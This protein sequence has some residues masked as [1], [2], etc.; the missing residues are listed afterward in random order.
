[1]VDGEVV[2]ESPAV[3]EI[4][5]YSHEALHALWPE[6][7]RDLNPQEYPVDLSKKAWDN[8]MALIDDIRAYVKE[9]SSENEDLEK[10]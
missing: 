1:M 9:L 10:Y 6:Y 7:R 5:Q 3:K 8:K 2:Y 4:R